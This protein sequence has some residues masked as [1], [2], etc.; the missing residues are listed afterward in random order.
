MYTMHFMEKIASQCANYKS[1]I[2]S[3]YGEGGDMY[4]G[5]FQSKFKIVWMLF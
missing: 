5:D 1:T 3:F 4:V 2:N